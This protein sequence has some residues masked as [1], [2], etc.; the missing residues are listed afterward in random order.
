LAQDYVQQRL[1]Q[2]S[3]PEE[4]TAVTDYLYYNAMLPGSGEHFLQSVLTS[5]VLAKRPLISRIPNL[6]VKSVTFLYGST[7]WMDI[8]GGLHTQ[9]LCQILHDQDPGSSPQVD[10]LRVPKAGHLL[11]L[12]NPEGTTAGMIHG[13]GGK[14]ANEDLP[15]LMDPAA[16]EPHESWME[17]TLKARRE[18]HKS[19]APL[20]TSSSIH[21]KRT[22][23]MSRNV[24]FMLWWMLIVLYLSLCSTLCFAFSSFSPL[25]QK[26]LQRSHV[27]CTATIRR[28][29]MPLI[30]KAAMKKLS[31]DE[32]NEKNKHDDRHWWPF[33][34][35]DRE[36]VRHVGEI[37]MREAEEL[38]GL[39]RSDRY[40]SVSILLQI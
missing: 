32:G 28:S 36:R 5:K 19:P 29:T 15:F 30:S 11:M 39:P 33:F 3:D 38:G 35:K 40:S 25:K 17:Q 8:S 21:T 37:K 6:K 26:P 1:P 20:A 2:I 4:S 12:E 22:M 27:P 9:K 14:V 18:P 13:A 7:D 34:R 23:T 16:E 24:P 31:R 10:V